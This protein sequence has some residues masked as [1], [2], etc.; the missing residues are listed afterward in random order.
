VKDL[1]IVY[2]K[3]QIAMQKASVSQG[4]HAYAREHTCK[5]P[6]PHTHSH[7]QAC[8]CARTQ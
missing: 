7:T 4:T 6:P 3:T 1:E 5:S 8:A 2:R